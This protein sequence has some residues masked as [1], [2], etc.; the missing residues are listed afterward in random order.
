MN[1]L[2]RT[3]ALGCAVC[4]LAP[5]AAQALIIDSDVQL[6]GP[7]GQYRYSYTLQNTSAPADDLG[8]TSFFLPFFGPQTTALLADSIETPEFWTFDVLAPSSTAWPYFRGDDPGAASYLP[9]GIDYTDADFILR[10]S[11]DPPDDIASFLLQIENAEAR[12]IICNLSDR[13]SD[14][15][16][17]QLAATLG[18]R[19]QW[20][21]ARVG[22]GESL[23]G[24]A[25]ASLLAST[26]GAGLIMSTSGAV[27]YSAPFL[28]LT[29]DAVPVPEPSTLVLFGAAV[30]ALVIAARKRRTRPAGATRAIDIVHS[31]GRSS[32]VF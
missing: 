17:A 11:L 7:A 23:G 5:A 32:P 26:V 10:F 31:E 24:F 18:E 29:Y 27:S 2:T 30:A 3:I 15:E 22:G 28:P 19:D 9:I 6:D 20:E 25:F 12:L 4:L 1:T 8:I 16:L 21:A 14:E 13:C